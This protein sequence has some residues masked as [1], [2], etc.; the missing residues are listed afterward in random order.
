M[1]FIWRTKPRS[2]FLNSLGLLDELCL[3]IVCACLALLD[4]AYAPASSATSLL[5]NIIVVTIFFN[6]SIRFI[7]IMLELLRR[8]CRPSS[9]DD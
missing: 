8:C 7:G 9:A 4:E 2:K 3:A 1:G 5:G 6:I